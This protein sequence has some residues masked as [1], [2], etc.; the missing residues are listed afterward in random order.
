MDFRNNVEKAIFGN[1]CI[2]AATIFWGVNYAF[3]KALAPVWMSDSAIAAVR[4][5]GGAILFWAAS[6]FIKNDKLDKDSLIRAACGGG[7]GLFGCI[8]LFVLS[9]GY[10]SAIDISIIMTLPPVFVILLEVVFLHRHPSW[11]EYCGIA[12]SFIGAAMV[13]LT[14]SSDAH[15][16]SNYLLGDFLA[17]AASACFAIY[18]VVLAKPTDIYKPVSLLRWV[19]LFAGLPGLFLLPGLFESP[20]LHTTEPAPWLE[21]AFI[22]FCP[23]FFAYF[24][25]QPAIKAIGAVLVALYQYL[26]PVVTAIAAILMGIE[27]PHWS[28]AFAMLIIIAG[29]LM[30]NW[31]KEKKKITNFKAN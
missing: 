1:A 9:L 8:Y 22:L 28:Q 5:I 6:L 27:Q 26:T 31:G 7:V 24:L 10:G 2:L 30:T 25:T 18:L 3:T 12:L 15:T 11:L 14:G 16:G 4:L 29:M 23:T 13:I 19:F 21:I 20:L 17:I